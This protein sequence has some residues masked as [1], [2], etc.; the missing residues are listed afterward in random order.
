M[1]PANAQVQ[2]ITVINDREQF[3]AGLSQNLVSNKYQTDKSLR[4]PSNSSQSANES[5]EFDAKRLKLLAS[6]RT[7]RPR[8]CFRELPVIPTREDIDE[9]T[10]YLR[11]N[12]TKVLQSMNED[13]IPLVSYLVNADKRVRT[14]EFLEA[15]NG[16]FDFTPILRHNEPDKMGD[17]VGPPTSAK[18][19][20]KQTLKPTTWPSQEATILNARQYESMKHVLSRELCLVQGPPGT[21]KTFVALKMAEMMLYN[22]L[23]DKPILVVCYTNHAL[24]RFLEG[25]LKFTDSIVRIGGNCKNT[26][27]ERYL[28]R[29]LQQSQANAK[30]VKLEQQKSRTILYNLRKT[31][32][33]LGK[34]TG[35][36]ILSDHELTMSGNEPLETYLHIHNFM[37][38]RKNCKVQ[39]R[40]S[41]RVPTRDPNFLN[42]Q[43]RGELEAEHF[44]KDEDILRGEMDSHREQIISSFLGCFNGNRKVE[45]IIHSLRAR[46]NQAED[47]SFDERWEL[48]RHYHWV[49]AKEL[50]RTYI[51]RCSKCS[52]STGHFVPA[53]RA[54]QAFA[55]HRFKD[56][57]AAIE[58]LRERA[59]ELRDEHRRQLVAIEE[60]Q[61]KATYNLIADRCAVVGMTTTGAAKYNALVR[62]LQPQIV[63]V[64]EAAEILEA[65]L[66]ASLTPSVKQLLL[67]G[68]HQQLQPSTTVHTLATEFGMQV[69]MFERLINNDFGFV[70]LH[71][72]HR[73]RD[74]FRQLFVPA[75]YHDYVSH[76]SVMNPPSIRGMTS[77][78]FF[79]KHSEPENSHSESH[80]KSNL[81][82]AQFV[83][84]LAVHLRKQ[85]YAPDEV[86][87]LATYRGQVAAIESAVKDFNKEKGFTTMKDEEKIEFVGNK[88][89]TTI[90]RKKVFPDLPVS[91]LEGMRI[92]TVDNYQGE[93]SRIIILSLVRSNIK[94]KIGFLSRDNRICVALS[95]AKEGLYAIGNLTLLARVSP[96]W[97]KICAILEENNCIGD[98]IEL[99]CEM[100]KD[101]I[102]VQKINDFERF[103]DGGCGKICGDRLP[104]G[105]YC[106]EPCHEADRCHKTDF[107]CRKPCPKRLSCGHKC[108]GNCSEICTFCEKSIQRK[109]GC[110]HRVVTNCQAPLD[111]IWC[112]SKCA[113]LLP[114]EHVC[115]RL[116][117]EPCGGPCQTAITKRA[118]CGHAA[119][120]LCKDRKKRKL[121]LEKKEITFDKCSHKIVLP[122][123][124]VN[125][126]LKCRQIRSMRCSRNHEFDT[127]CYEATGQDRA[128]AICPAAVF[129]TLQ[130]GHRFEIRCSLV[131]RWNGKL[132]DLTDFPCP[133]GCLNKVTL[134]P[135]SASRTCLTSCNIDSRPKGRCTGQECHEY[136][137]KTLFCGH[138]CPGFCHTQCSPCSEPITYVC[139]HEQIDLRCMSSLYRNPCD[140]P[141]VHC[142]H[143]SCEKN[144][145]SCFCSCNRRC[146]KIPPCGIASH[147]CIGLCGEQCICGVCHGNMLV[148]RRPMAGK[149]ANP[150]N[151]VHYFRLPCGHCCEVAWLDNNMARHRNLLKFPTCPSCHQQIRFCRR[152]KE[153]LTKISNQMKALVQ[154]VFGNLKANE[155]S[156]IRLFE[157]DKLSQDLRP[158]FLERDISKY[159]L[160]YI[161]CRLQM[162]RSKKLDIRQ[163]NI[164]N[165][166]I[167]RQQSLINYAS[168]NGFVTRSA[169][170]ERDGNR[171]DDP[172]RVGLIVKLPSEPETADNWRICKQHNFFQGGQCSKCSRKRTLR[173][174]RLQ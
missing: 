64:E 63:I 98:S 145:G 137:G 23:T 173:N 14:P 87:I 86:T 96:T 75:I 76:P 43:D 24:D 15:R 131:R 84:R 3:A 112:R 143:K 140:K 103:P 55:K 81:F 83:V 166:L 133:E 169:L 28:L 106:R 52:V 89:I 110:G 26:R 46:L 11:P 116:C 161:Q 6:Y 141:A 77:N 16:K 162:S 57:E 34:L 134:R 117:G 153:L 135:S 138:R 19:N 33:L 40:A 150:N 66:L 72:Q 111:K 122:C 142:E 91:P 12:I 85:S 146:Q 168:E 68:D 42:D 102:V 7:D 119:T 41:T 2:A 108:R 115:P 22:R 18:I 121:C 5:S 39:M 105:H 93:E 97:Q 17:A 58:C 123:Y 54:Q 65:H 30:S 160:K 124:K 154:R 73:M 13:Q 62:R 69:S 59:E 170:A 32:E 44:L 158:I 49:V 107:R 80:S 155:K 159:E 10:T 99:K 35:K 129:K 157:H 95:R 37:M 167:F 88:K 27:L 149:V 126:D 1:A 92:T 20:G 50:A 171:R 56:V 74:K 109:L 156:M 38:S 60:A 125:K 53:N 174:R 4:A 113:R 25:M 29:S 9:E 36:M 136:C 61:C 101:Q 82:E 120:F 132:C 100:H 139:P 152:Y 114:C 31:E 151:N 71:E 148:K 130:C 165:T 21:G 51:E 147:S 104:C 163:D 128:D 79:M 90:V 47:L 45:P 67:I 48:Y 70:Q 144:C 94:S 118:K 164:S 172:N 78:L 127:L 8:C